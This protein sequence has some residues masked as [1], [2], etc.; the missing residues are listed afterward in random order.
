M[1]NAEQMKE[2]LDNY[3]SN[4]AEEFFDANGADC[5]CGNGE[6]HYNFK[7]GSKLKCHWLFDDSVCVTEIMGD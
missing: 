3:H 1:T 6:E 5:L 4:D 7:D 2:M